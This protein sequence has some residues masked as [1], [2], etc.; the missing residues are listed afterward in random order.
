MRK[1]FGVLLTLAVL[2]L[3][4]CGLSVAAAADSGDIVNVG[5]VWLGA[6]EYVTNENMQ[7]SET[8]TATAGAPAGSGYAYLTGNET[9]GYTLTL[10]GFD[11]HEKADDNTAA[12]YT[13]VPLT[14]EL[15]GNNQIENKNEY[16]YGI[17]GD[18]TSRV[19]VHWKLLRC[20]VSVQMN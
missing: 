2:A 18:N 20:L 13:N 1:R 12:I 10:N 5:N 14:I 15:I 16:G 17:L 19:Q 8:V 11:N 4:I 9:D 7:S 3:L 6:G